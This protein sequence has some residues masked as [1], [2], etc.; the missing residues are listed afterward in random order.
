MACSTNCTET[1]NYEFETRLRIANLYV[2][3]DT[4]PAASR[5]LRI[6]MIGAKSEVQRFTDPYA[7][8]APATTVGRAYQFLRGVSYIATSDTEN[9]KHSLNGSDHMRLLL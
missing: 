3:K 2:A 4:I 8:I 5:S 6:C 1:T 9:P 7:N